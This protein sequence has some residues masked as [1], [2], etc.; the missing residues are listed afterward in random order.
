VVDFHGAFKPCGLHR[1]YP[2]VLNYEGVHGLETMKWSKPGTDQLTYDVTFPY[3]RMAAGPVDYTQGAMR[4]CNYDLYKPCYTNPVSQGTRC[5]QL[6]MYVVFDS[7]FN[8]LCDAPQ[9]YEQ[10]KECTE[11]IAKIPTVWDETIALD[12]KVG[13][14]I[15]LAR[16]N[17]DKWYI[18]GLSGQSARTVTIDLDFLSEGKWQ[19][20]LFKDGVNAVRHA[21]DYK[22]I[23]N[24]AGRTMTV[25]MTSGGG[26]AAMIYKK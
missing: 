2:N 13:E 1:T 8:M 7:P 12:G 21:E 23:I 9:H 10:A 18:G 15:V 26:F 24:D 5:H 17:G 20:E 25:E 3:I 11:F 22:R 4:N 6:G 14:Y 16:R 19:V